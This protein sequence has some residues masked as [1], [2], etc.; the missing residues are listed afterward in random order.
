VL[1]MGAMSPKPGNDMMK[2]SDLTGDCAAI[3]D[4]DLARDGGGV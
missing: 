4:P 3:K 2:E 1:T